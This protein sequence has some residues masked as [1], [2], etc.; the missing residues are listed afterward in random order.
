MAI[1]A[2]T[3]KIAKEEADKAMTWLTK[4]VAA[5]WKD[6]EHIKKDADLDSLRER[7]DFKKL[8][9]DLEKGAKSSKPSTAVAQ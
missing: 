6:A 5:G 2:T 8:V 4:A 3:A 1:A 9:A 7:E